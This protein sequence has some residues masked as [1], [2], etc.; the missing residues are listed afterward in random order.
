MECRRL[1]HDEVAELRSLIQTGKHSAETNRAQ[2]V[3][4][5]DRVTDMADITLLTD[6]G[7]SQIFGLRR[8][9]LDEGVSVLKDKRI[10][11]PKELLTRKERE[12][13]VATVR[14]KTPRDVGYAYAHWTTG[15]LGDWI[16]QTYKARYKS[17]TSLYLV[18]KQARFTYHKPGRVYHEHNA[19]EIAAWNTETKPRLSA[20]WKQRNTVILAADEMILTTQTTIQ[21]AWLPQGEYPRIE[22]ATSGRKRRSVYGFLNCKTGREHAFKTERQNMGVS[23]DI[24]KQIRALYPQKQIVLCW[25]NAGWHKGRTVMEFIKSD[26]HMTVIPFPRYAP[27][28]NPQEHVWKSGRSAV[29]H[30]TF[31]ADID[32]ATDALVDYFNRTTFNYALLGFSPIS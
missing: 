30:N 22:C 11:K 1:T 27:E 21:K 5:L 32:K 17:K 12:A 20:L 8:R 25:D 3:L 9:F 29:T 2:A 15:I 24:L 13:I 18:F 28:L 7:R 31:I 23:A 26:E 14:T 6:L 16:A 4:L 19:E 10:G